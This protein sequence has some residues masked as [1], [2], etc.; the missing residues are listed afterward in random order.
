MSNYYQIDKATELALE[1]FANRG[2]M[3][4]DMVNKLIKN[5]R[6]YYKVAEELG[7][8][9]SPVISKRLMRNIKIHGAALAVLAP[10]IYGGHKLRH[11]LKHKGLT[12]SASKKDHDMPH[13]LDQDRPA[14]VKEIYKSLK[15]D[16]PG[17]PAEVKARI[18]ARKGKKSPQS[19]KPPETGGPAYK[20]PLA[21]KRKGEE[22]VK[23][24]ADGF[25]RKLIDKVASILEE[26]SRFTKE[27]QE[28]LEAL[29]RVIIGGRPRIQTEI[30][31]KDHV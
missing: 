12:K 22:Y 26:D 28:K 21:Y 30:Y 9:A 11:H 25:I 6:I 13:F 15:R 2:L 18:A 10:L 16:H 24:A 14:K 8:Y 31:V 23:E 20:A 4:K 7:K 1:D 17:M 19:R 3:D 29:E 5:D 27:E